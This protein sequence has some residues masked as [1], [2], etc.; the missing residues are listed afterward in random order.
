M[1]AAL[2]FSKLAC[3]VTFLNSAALPKEKALLNFDFDFFASFLLSA[4]RCSA[5]GLGAATTLGLDAASSSALGLM[6]RDKGEGLLGPEGVRL[7]LS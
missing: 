4:A 6:G 2:L 7:L 5:A 1:L 3:A